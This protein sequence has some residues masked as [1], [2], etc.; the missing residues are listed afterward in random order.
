MSIISSIDDIY[1]IAGFLLPGQ[2]LT[3]TNGQVSGYYR[4]I[5]CINPEWDHKKVQRYLKLELK[6]MMHSDK[7]PSWTK[8]VSDSSMCQV[9]EAQKTCWRFINEGI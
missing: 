7:H 8:I 1:Q 6:T 5:L 4:R 3:D 2:R 9:N